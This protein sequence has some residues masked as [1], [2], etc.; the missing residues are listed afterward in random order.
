MA[1]ITAQMVKDLRD[2]TG[3]GMGDCKK[4]LVETDGNM[5]NAVDFLRK[6]GLAS[7]GK[8]KDRDANEGLVAYCEINDSATTAFVEMY[9]ETDF[10]AK[11]DKF[12]GLLSRFCL[13]AASKN[14]D[15]IESFLSSPSLDDASLT[16]QQK[17]DELISILGENIG[18]ARI[19]VI[20]RG[21]NESVGVYSHNNGQIVAAVHLTGSADKA[22]L[23]R[24]LAQ[25]I[26][27]FAPSYLSSAEVPAD[28]KM[29]ELD[30]AAEKNAGKPAQVLEK[31]AAGALAK[32][33]A[34]NCLLDQKYLHDDSKSVAQILEQEKASIKQHIYWKVGGAKP[35]QA[36]S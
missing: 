22:Q 2:R 34:E 10:V 28:I 6:K 5:D 12:T 17:T 30:I 23:A 29:R 11:T 24:N 35:E 3:A 18:I 26:V 14:P 25:H 19:A 8:K 32:Y 33:Y 1:D 13:Q 21:P 16:V 9:C 4:A 36:E 31:I 27:A 7:A 20:N 15:S